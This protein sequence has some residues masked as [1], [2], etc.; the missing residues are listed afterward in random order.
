MP[1]NIFRSITEFVSVQWDIIEKCISTH[2]QLFDS[3]KTKVIN[4]PQKSE[5][6]QI[7]SFSVYSLC[8]HFCVHLQLVF[9]I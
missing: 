6:K 3:Y 1:W 7:L 8:A 9:N 4:L 5:T 2:N